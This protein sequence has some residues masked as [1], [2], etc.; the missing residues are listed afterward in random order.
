MLSDNNTIHNNNN[1]EWSPRPLLQLLQ[2]NG[3]KKEKEMCD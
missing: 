1:N 3:E 2:N